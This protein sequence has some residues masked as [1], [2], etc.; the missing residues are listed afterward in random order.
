MSAKRGDFIR[1]D[2]KNK[3][4]YLKVDSVRNNPEMI[5]GWDPGTDKYWQVEPEYVDQVIR[6][7]DRAYQFM[8]HPKKFPTT[9][10]VTA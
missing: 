2:W 10:E 4:R 5:F 1:F 7:V 6:P 9:E 8:S 3:R